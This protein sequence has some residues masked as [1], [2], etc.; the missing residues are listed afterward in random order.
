MIAPKIDFS[1]REERIA[2][3]RERFSCKAPACGGCGSCKMPGGK[4][5]MTTFDEYIEGKKEFSAVA[6][7]LWNSKMRIDTIQRTKELLRAL[8]R[9]WE[10]SVRAAHQFL[11]EEDILSLR[12]FVMQ[13]LQQ[14]LV[15]AVCFEDDE[16]LGFIGIAERKV[17]MLFVEPEHI[18]KGV[19]R[20]L[21]DWGINNCQVNLIDVNEQNPKALAIYQHWGFKAYERTELDDQGNPFPIVRMRLN[22]TAK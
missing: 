12:P 13:G 5:A 21:M 7:K 18:G 20:A 10:R 2:F 4:S 8:A 1:D 19:G 6:S 3:I 11:S 22:K 14:I 17:E 15:L 9:L 16:P